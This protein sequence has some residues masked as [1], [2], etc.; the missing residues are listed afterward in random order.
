MGANKQQGNGVKMS[1]R[2]F[3]LCDGAGF[4]V[5]PLPNVSLGEPTAGAPVGVKTEPTEIDRDTLL[6]VQSR[7]QYQK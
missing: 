1:R 3:V 2:W 6:L 4:G 7:Q 5:F